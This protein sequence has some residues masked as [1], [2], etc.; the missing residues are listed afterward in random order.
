MEKKS[1]TGATMRK[2]FGLLI[3]SL[4]SSAGNRVFNAYCKQ[5]GLHLDDPAPDAV[6]LDA[7]AKYGRF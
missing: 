4:G 2:V 6:I 3:T 7:F 5:Y 1:T